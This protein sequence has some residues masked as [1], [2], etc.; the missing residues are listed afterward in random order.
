MWFNCCSRELMEMDVSVDT[1]M[2]SQGCV[3]TSFKGMCPDMSH[4]LSEHADQTIFSTCVLLCSK[5]I[6]WAPLS[7][8]MCNVRLLPCGYI[9][10][11]NSPIFFS[12][13][14]SP[15]DQ[16]VG[17]W[18]IIIELVDAAH[19]HDVYNRILPHIHL[20]SL[21][22]YAVILWIHFRI[23][24]RGIWTA[25]KYCL[26]ISIITILINMVFNWS[27]TKQCIT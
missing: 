6:W 24:P 27:K 20:Q 11:W 25:T 21:I 9:A 7:E 1:I 12:V 3:D 10:T 13:Y 17:Q 23:T 22:S 14:S 15:S 26:V 5:L 4:K 16:I 8:V 18:V 2:W 19:K